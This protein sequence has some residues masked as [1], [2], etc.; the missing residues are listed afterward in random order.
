MK[1]FEKR[2]IITAAVTFVAAIG[3]GHFM[4]YGIAGATRSAP[5][6]VAAVHQAMPV[7]YIETS[8]LMS[9]MQRFEP[10]PSAHNAPGSSMVPRAPEAALMPAALPDLSGTRPHLPEDVMRKPQSEAEYDLD[11]MG[12]QCRPR[13]TAHAEPGALVRLELSAP[14][15]REARVDIEHSGLRFAVKTDR[16]GAISLKVPVLANPAEFAVTVPG[17]APVEAMVPVQ[18]MHGHERVA[19]Q[20]TADANL[21]IHALEFGAR[22][23][24][25]GHVSAASPHSVERG[26]MAFGGYLARLGD[27][28]AP[29]AP[30][31]EIYSFPTGQFGRSGVVRL[32]I[33]ARVTRETCDDDL[34]AH[35]L[36]TRDTGHLRRI[37]V[38]LAMPGCEA[39]GDIL[40]LKNVLQD[41]KIAQN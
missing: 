10:I 17:Y 25:A 2:Q 26:A 23:G 31:A 35:A 38:T 14:C 33:E 18:N 12:M 29:G 40:V 21:S 32:Q 3:A 4:Q 15:N 11:A 34:H 13:L 36:Q 30:V 16:T 39:I 28:D 1:K 7:T 37:D 8:T 27:D 5:P 9:A 22:P 24:S 41:L 20:S 19:L 6:E